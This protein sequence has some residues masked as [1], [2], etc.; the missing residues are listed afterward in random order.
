[1]NDLEFG[2]LQR[3]NLRNYWQREDI[4]F[5]PWLAAGENITLLGDAIGMELEVQDQEA[6]V[7]PLRADILC[8]NVRDNSLVLIENQLEKTDHSHL[9]QLLTYAAGL[10]AVALVWIVESFTEEHR[11]A[12][13]WLNRITDEEILFFGLEIELW[14]IGDSAPA[15]KFNL[16]VKPNDWSKTMKE[17]AEAS[18]HRNSPGQQLQVD[19]WTSFG[20]FLSKRKTSVKPPKPY[21]SNWMGYGLGRAGANLV[22]IINQNEAIVC[23]ET[24]NREHPAWF[25]L[26]KDSQSEIEQALGHE[27]TWEER[28]DMKY[29]F[30]RV[31]SEI[32]LQDQESWP[33]VHEWM[34]K[35]MEAF[36][37]VFG[38]RIKR[39]KDEDWRQDN[40][41]RA[42]A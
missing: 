32:D 20:E 8:K 40:E 23:L 9:G 1:M 24:N 26:L 29:A 10:N 36:R 25:H 6:K 3:V 14:R 15:P 13:D 33:Q 4:H 7:G 11:A 30:V 5:T 18:R 38:S 28:P 17:A 35:E 37:R 42:D 31:R 19:Y 2:R 34:L 41:Q 27:L 16:A 12:M 39:L 21:P 22:V